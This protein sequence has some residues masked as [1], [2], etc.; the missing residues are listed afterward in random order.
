MLEV[1]KSV[2]FGVVEG[3]TEWLPISSTGH[4]ILVQEFINF[5]HVSAAFLSM[6][7]V[8]IQ[9]GAILAVVTIYFDRLNPFKA[10]KTEREVRLT[11]QLWMKVVIAA[12]P[13]VVFG[14][15]LDDW[16][17][18]HLYNFVVVALMLI[19]YG[20]AFIMVEK[21]NANRTPEVTDLAKMP[22]RTALSIGCYQVLSL[23]PGTSRSGATIL[24]GMLSGTS[25]SVATEFTFFLG[26]PMMF[27]ASF[28]K[29]VKLLIKGVEVSGF[30]WA[31]LLIAMVTAYVVS[32]YV[33]RFLT[34][35]VKKHDFT[36]FGK[37][38]IVL[39]GLLLVYYV[40]RYLF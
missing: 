4:L 27:G 40:L 9:L 25:R 24:G 15:L 10:G 30:E 23:V 31:L 5:R 19:L 26:I 38:R 36:I 1:L 37:Y 39:G 29:L 28:L 12:L 34:D 13:G 18:D 35:F 32:L 22:Y 20:L 8:L 33:I 3:V 14:L 16:M 6:F 7:N 21:R 2:F 11:W 17:D